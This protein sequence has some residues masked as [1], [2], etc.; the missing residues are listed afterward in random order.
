M[1][2]L[3]HQDVGQREIGPIDLWVGVRLRDLRKSADFTQEQAG[4]ELGVS[5]STVGKMENGSQAVT[6]GRLWALCQAY[7]VEISDVFDGLKEE[8]ASRRVEHAPSAAGFDEEGRRFDHL[9]PDFIPNDVVEGLNAM[10]PIRRNLAFDM[11]RGLA[12]RRRK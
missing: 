4:R 5:A 8:M 1:S 7:G 3:E 11:I 2:D 10:N 6:A 12:P 9:A